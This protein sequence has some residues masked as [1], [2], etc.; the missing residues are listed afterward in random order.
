MDSQ[1]Y[2]FLRVIQSNS[3]HK[4]INIIYVLKGILIILLA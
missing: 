3:I 2:K 4:S 1:E